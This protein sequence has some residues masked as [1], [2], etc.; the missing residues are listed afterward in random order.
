MIDEN[1]TEIHPLSS[2]VLVN[3]ILT[4]FVGKWHFLLK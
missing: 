3:R 1:N 2:F 4:N